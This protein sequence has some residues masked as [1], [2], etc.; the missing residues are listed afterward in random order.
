MGSGGVSL[1]WP[2]SLVMDASTPPRAKQPATAPSHVASSVTT[3]Y[4]FGGGAGGVVSSRRRQ[5]ASA[6]PELP[7]TCNTHT[8]KLDQFVRWMH[9]HR[10]MHALC[11]PQSDTASAGEPPVE[12]SSATLM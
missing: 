1:A 4:G 12:S 11:E 2:P 5:W 6:E 10:R 8:I 3:V 7:D 9:A